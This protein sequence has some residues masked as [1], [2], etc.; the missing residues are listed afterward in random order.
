[1]GISENRVLR[2]FG[3]KKDAITGCRGKL[4]CEELN[5]LL[6]RL[7]KSKRMTYAGHVARKRDK[8]N[9]YTTLV[10]AKGTRPPGRP[11]RT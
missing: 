11:R 5:N 8:R 3:P 7:I 1:L 4:H 6:I 10:I 9:E 2:I